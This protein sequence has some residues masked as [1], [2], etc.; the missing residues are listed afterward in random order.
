MKTKTHDW[1]QLTLRDQSTT[2]VKV[3]AITCLDQDNM[4]CRV[5]VGGTS[6]HVS[7]SDKE[8]LKMILEGVEFDV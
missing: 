1:I 5:D 4:F 2:I 6:L 3:G 7:E 8:I